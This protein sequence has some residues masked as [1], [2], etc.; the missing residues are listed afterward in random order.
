MLSLEIERLLHGISSDDSEIINK[1]SQAFVDLKGSFD[2][3]VAV[4][5]TVVTFR[6]QETAETICKGEIH[7][8]GVSISHRIAFSA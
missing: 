1:L 6:V 7:S 5:T 2:S 3:G 8:C 4:Q